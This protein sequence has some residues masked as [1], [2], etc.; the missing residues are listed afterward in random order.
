MD[1][2]DFLVEK[3]QAVLKRWLDYV[4]QTYPAQTAEMLKSRKN[5]FTNPVGKIISDS[6]GA[7]YDELVRQL[8]GKEQEPGEERLGE[9]LV[10]IIKVRAVQDFTASG[11]L[12]FIFSLKK[13]AREEAEGSGFAREEISAF[14][15]QML[16]FGTLVD[17]L[18]L[19]AFDFYMQCREK[20]YE[21]KAAEVRDHTFRLLQQANLLVEKQKKEKGKEEHGEERKN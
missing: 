10:N 6:L 12:G 1:L 4:L 2:K 16:E 9:F 15:R 7:V 21:L 18:A 19:G 11:A 8:G 17:R 20:I 13:A 5:Q 3:R 14:Y